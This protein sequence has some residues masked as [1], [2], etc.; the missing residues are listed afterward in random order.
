MVS[1]LCLEVLTGCNNHFHSSFA[2]FLFVCRA[3]V[4]WM[5]YQDRGKQALTGDSAVHGSVGRYCIMM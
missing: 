4:K 1:R 5:K 3:Y 2:S